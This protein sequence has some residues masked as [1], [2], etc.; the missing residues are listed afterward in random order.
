[1]LKLTLESGEIVVGAPNYVTAKVA[2]FRLADG[3]YRTV[4]RAQIVKTERPKKTPKGDA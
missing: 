3:T 4:N 2:E 1:M